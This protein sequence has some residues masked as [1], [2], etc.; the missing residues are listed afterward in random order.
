[1][2]IIIQ[3]SVVASVPFL[4]PRLFHIRVTR[5]KRLTKL[6]RPV[7]EF[8]QPLLTSFRKSRLAPRGA[9]DGAAVGGLKMTA[10]PILASSARVKLW[11]GTAISLSRLAFAPDRHVSKCQFRPVHAGNF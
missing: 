5:R 2:L 6:F 10:S 3:P 7:L 4:F 9:R 11:K 8:R 1:M